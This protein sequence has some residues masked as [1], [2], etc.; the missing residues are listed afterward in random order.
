MKI[1]TCL[2]LSFFSINIYAQNDFSSSWKKIDEFEKKGLTKSA[3]EE[4]Y[5]ILKAAGASNNGP[6]Q[7]KAAL[8]YIRF[9]ASSQQDEIQK[10]ILFLDSLARKTTSPSKNILLSLEASSLSQ[11]KQNNIWKFSNRTTVVN[12]SSKD[13]NTWSLSKLNARITQLYLQSL[14]NENILKNTPIKVYDAIIDKGKNTEL[15]RP[16]LFDFLA[17]R[18]L[19]YFSYAENSVS[20]PAYKFIINNEK[21][22]SPAKDFITISIQSKDSSSNYIKALQLYQQLLSFHLNDAEP[23]ALIDADLLRLNF[24]HTHG[25]FFNKNK[26]Y[27]NAL[28]QMQQTYGTHKGVAEVLYAKANL[29][30]EMEMTKL[31][32]NSKKRAKEIADSI[33]TLF[34]NSIAAAKSKELIDD[35]KTPYLSMEA[36]K[37]YLPGESSKAL[38][39]YK[40]IATVYFKVFKVSREEIVQINNF[41]E[42]ETKIN[43]ILKKTK[44]REWNIHLPDKNDFTEHSAE[45]KIEPLESGYYFLVASLKNDFTDDDN[46]VSWQLISISSISL[47][48]SADNAFYIVDRKNGA[49][50]ANAEITAFTQQ[51]DYTTNRNNYVRY[52]NYRS[53]KNGFF[54]INPPKESIEL[55][56]NIKWNK[57]ELFIDDNFYVETETK[58]EKPIAE[59]FL[60][61]D[62]AIYRPGQ[63]LFFKGIVYKKDSAYTAINTL[64]DYTTTV[65]LY[66]A[67]QQ[68]IQSIQL[69]TN[70]FGSYSGKFILPEGQMNGQFFIKDS[71]TNLMKFFKVEEYKRPKFYVEINIPETNYQLNDSVNVNGLVKAYAGNNI[72]GAKVSYR[73][74]R[75]TRYPYPINFLKIAWP[76][77]NNEQEIV[78]G[79]SQ[80][81]NDGSFRINFNL[82]PDETVDPS[83]RPIFN[84]E[85]SVD[86]TDVNGE[87]RSKT[88][89]IIAAWHNLQL[90][91][92]T[93]SSEIADSLKSISINSTNINNIFTSTRAQLTIEKI[94]SPS[95]I[96]KQRYWQ[97][98]DQFIMTK[99]EH[100][101]M[102][103]ND[104][105]IH[106]DKPE[107]WPIINKVFEKTDSTKPFSKWDIGKTLSAGWYKITVSA[108]DK[109]GTDIINTKFIELTDPKTKTNNALAVYASKLSAKPG[110]V[111]SIVTSSGFNNIWLLQQ[112]N[113]KNFNQTDIINTN[114]PIVTNFT[115]KE[116]E[117]GGMDYA[118]LIVKKNRIYT[119]HQHI[120]IPYANKELKI[121]YATYRDK[122][123][124]GS[125]ENWKLNISGANAEKKAAE[126]LINMYDASLDQFAEHNW[127]N[128][129]ELWPV[130]YDGFGF[131]Q[132][133]FNSIE[134][135]NKIDIL[136]P[137]YNIPNK[138]YPYLL[139]YQEFLIWNLNA[140]A[141]GT[142][143]LEFAFTG[144]VAGLTSYRFKN[145]DNEYKKSEDNSDTLKTTSKTTDDTNIQIRKN[146]NETAFFFPDL[147]TDSN[148]NISFSFTIP[149]ALTKWKL[150]TLAHTPDLASGYDEKEIITQK[151]L[152]VQPNMPRFIRQGD[153][154]ELPVKIVNV[155]NKEL[156][157]TVQMEL[158]DA[159][160][161]QPIDGWIK[162]IF[163]VQY[164]TAD[165]NGSMSLVFPIE[166]PIGFSS[167]LGYRIKAITSDKQFSDGEENAIPVLSNRMLV[168][169]SMPLNMRNTNEKKFR[170]EKLINSSNSGTLT[171][172]LLTVEYF[173]NPLWLVVQALPY[174]NDPAK[175]SADDYFFQIYANSL[176]SHI[177]KNAPAIKNVFDKWRITDTTAL[178]S[179][180]S[181]NEELKS[182][183]LQ[184]TPWVFDAEN[185]TQ[186]KKNILLL[187]DLVQ[188]SKQNN[189]AL[190]K[191]KEL[192]LP[193]GAFSW[194]KGGR[195]DR[196]ITQSIITGLGKLKHLNALPASPDLQKIISSGINYLDKKIKDD[197]N[198]LKKFK[199]KLN[200]NNLS[201]IAVQYLY[202]RSF[203]E[204]KI[205]A[206]VKIAYDYYNNQSKQY[207]LSQ[208]KMMQA[209]IAITASR[210]SSFTVAQ[211]IIR[212][213]KENAI[214][215]E[216]LGM[217]YK[218]FNNG[219]YYWYQNP[220]E[221]Q[222]V[223]I[224]A[225]EEV[226][227]NAAT[228]NDLRTWLIKQKQTQNW[229]SNKAT[230]DACYALLISNGKQNDQLNYH[231]DVTIQLGNQIISN[232]SN[233]QEAGTGYFKQT[234]PTGK[235]EPS[236]GNIEVKMNK[237]AN[238]QPSWGA[239]YWQYF[240][241]M[242]KITSASTPLQLVKKIYIEKNTDNGPA[243]TEVKDGDDLQIG[244]KVKIRIELRVDRAME[245][246]HMK[247]MRSATMEPVNVIS[248]YKYQDGLS[249]YETTK[250]ASTNFFFNSL[251]RG[252]YVFEYP[253]FVTQ[254]GNYSNGITTIQC[255][256]APE[257]SSHSN[258]IRINITAKK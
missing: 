193:N 197:Y 158:F 189:N 210:Q 109:N 147:Q 182:V 102:F 22:F 33:V 67:N 20:D 37:V 46:I 74:T 51:Y 63:T 5:K 241:D 172:Q 50:L 164:F 244:D 32:L 165:A 11:F 207:W 216:E 246:I 48:G 157:G 94:Q 163:P 75:K 116:K 162:N 192:Q 143:S 89:N 245:Y 155:T 92:L 180:L 184:E 254:A 160:T 142:T 175:E 204:N 153:K 110:D 71:L 119:A 229:K 206:D 88:Q 154:A 151:E 124:P 211:N 220:V 223:I 45:F 107:N 80:T 237:P 1:F 135:A 236:M 247:D 222:T 146:F 60:F 84:Y 4:S 232:I 203:F 169:E 42:D 35:I 21:Y 167:V 126:V 38:L 103:P 171:N 55:S 15:L 41:S 91:I 62:R 25:V 134:S 36:E 219:G 150:M 87:T 234:I 8:F 136:H 221:S 230:A 117:S 39:K 224:E 79:I 17:F 195:D 217:F 3:R 28:W 235:I 253:M 161:N 70:K 198:D 125:K 129:S 185:E 99:S 44:I 242:D 145:G 113:K 120:Y 19:E 40:S 132:P 133:C 202:M 179:N 208:N 115:I 98:P 54:K 131:Y 141:Y 9:V 238:A 249:Y 127:N 66:N 149:E 85:I 18:A 233:K 194:F 65:Q 13:I 257:F 215:S 255:L 130:V 86:V 226:D 139:Y 73:V 52:K 152:M 61:T 166:I 69:I 23:S 81:N 93:S 72:G 190:A 140:S 108:K 199:I 183:L 214:I 106:E 196:Y 138:V 27:E 10:N 57:D 251:P 114:K 16:T 101:A 128:N 118:F 78:N 148:G 205:P 231:P 156:T 187:F 168:T 258:G 6:Q 59:S 30:S 97:T 186:Q 178:L 250:D 12:D 29:F 90:E 58:K 228:L 239:V 43:K 47:I 122:L 181:K 137:N 83:D 77:N 34:P 123:N 191:L 248:E 218:E 252:T 24:I 104:P 201:Q 173:T 31:K 112:W 188:I 49:P 159:A 144:K 174:L 100:D 227:K 105:Y 256:Y 170:F 243:L 76:G 68:K 177:L 121:S 225:F 209:M 26:L 53:D 82:I 64:S 2:L 95:V 213:L 56:F 14:Q 212:S 176:A 7:I 200:K 111:I 240:E 96:Y